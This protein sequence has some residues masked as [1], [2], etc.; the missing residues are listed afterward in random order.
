VV[1]GHE[2]HGVPPPLF[3]ICPFEHGHWKIGED[4]MKDQSLLS[5]GLIFLGVP[6]PVLSLPYFTLPGEKGGCK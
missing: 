1:K 6:S 5:S 4:L 2:D 3:V